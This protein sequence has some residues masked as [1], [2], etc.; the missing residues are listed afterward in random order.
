MKRI[1]EE[2]LKAALDDLSVI[3][4]IIS[5]DHLTHMAAFH[6]QQAIEKSFKAVVEEYEIG[7]VRIHNLERLLE[8]ISKRIELA[9]D[10]IIIEKLD[11]LYIDARYPA[12]LGLL[13]NGK[14][15]REDAEEFYAAAQNIYSSVKTHLEKQSSPLKE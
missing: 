6:S 3:K 10:I 14:P 8:L 5:D 1:A 13:P 2:W 15:A 9:V 11:K 12:D 4:K 7:P